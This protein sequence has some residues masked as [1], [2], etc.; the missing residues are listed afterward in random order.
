[1]ASELVLARLQLEQLRGTQGGSL[2]QHSPALQAPTSAQPSHRGGASDPKPPPTLGLDPL[3]SHPLPLLGAAARFPPA[4]AVATS[5]SSPALDPLL[6]DVLGILST[7]SPLPPLP[8]TG[9][10]PRHWATAVA[11]P[12][13]TAKTP[14]RSL[15][16]SPSTSPFP[17]QPHRT[18]PP[19]SY[20]ASGGSAH[21]GDRNAALQA[22]AHPAEVTSSFAAE[23]EVQTRELTWHDS[24]CNIM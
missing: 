8:S 7:G 14:A 10:R 5:T 4:T 2:G 12:A 9:P 24:S 21:R 13:E 17:L 22:T 15:T 19:R 1:M 18:S 20:S 6:M 3:A 23:Q 16:F 11:A